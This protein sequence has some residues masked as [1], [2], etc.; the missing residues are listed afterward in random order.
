MDISMDPL[1][2]RIHI[3]FLLGRHERFLR[4]E[5]NTLG[6]ELIDTVLHDLVVGL[7]NSFDA[8]YGQFNCSELEL[9]NEF[10]QG[11]VWNKL[12]KYIE[13]YCLPK[14]TL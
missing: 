5:L 11:Q 6:L 12:G 8:L 7:D 2:R 13:L 3:A 1:Q 4:Q 10:I 14:K 9:L